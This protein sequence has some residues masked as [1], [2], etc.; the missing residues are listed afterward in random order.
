MEEKIK[1]VEESINEREKKSKGESMG[2]RMKGYEAQWTTKLDRKLPFIIR[3]DGHKFSSYTRPFKKPFDE[4]I[5]TVMVATTTDLMAYF[6]PTTG[7]TCSDEITLLFPPITEEELNTNE[8]ETT[9]EA[10][11]EEK[12][13]KKKKEK[14]EEATLMFSGKV[15]KIVS[16]AA[17][18]AS[19]RF[20]SH[21][22]K[23]TFDPATEGRL[24]QHVETSTPHFDARIFQVPTNDELLNNVMWRCHFDYRRNSISGLAR[25]HFSTKQLHKLNS[26]QLLE[27]LASKGVSWEGMPDAYK[28]GTFLKK[29]RY[30]IEAV[31][32]KGE[33]VIAFR[34]RVITRSFDIVYTEENLKFICSKYI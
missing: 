10:A 25:C 7:F 34:R 1:I 11:T 23:Q 17:G 5:S 22:A 18:Y 9:K 33:K 29:E 26:P 32:D 24:I 3:L 19:A 27:M 15:Q 6:N 30:E 14:T 13:D 31:N 21:M 2:D 16:L 12:E 8:E 20:N 28:Y 4:R